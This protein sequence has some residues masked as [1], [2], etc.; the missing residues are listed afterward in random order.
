MNKTSNYLYHQLHWLD[1]HVNTYNSKNFVAAICNI[2]FKAQYKSSIVSYHG[3][4]TWYLVK[5]QWKTVPSNYI[6][7]NRYLVWV[8]CILSITGM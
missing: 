7:P 1:I 5:N 8:V 6:S 3:S 4:T 2:F